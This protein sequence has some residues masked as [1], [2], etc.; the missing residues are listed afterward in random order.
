EISKRLG[1]Y[2]DNQDNWEN[3]TVINLVY[4]LDQKNLKLIFDCGV[5]DFFYDANKRLHKKMLERKI[6]HDYIE[7]PGKHNIEYWT[8][9][10]KY[11]F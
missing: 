11:Q 5:D 7:R 6:P 8:N 9:S 4:L 1:V 10:I 2:S 3:N